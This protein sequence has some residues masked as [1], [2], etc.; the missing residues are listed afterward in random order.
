MNR[1]EAHTD[2]TPTRSSASSFAA[3]TDGTGE[4][5]SRRTKPLNGFSLGA[6]SVVS[7]FGTTRKKP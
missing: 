7:P 1:T 6:M 3:G 5:G 2:A 4:L